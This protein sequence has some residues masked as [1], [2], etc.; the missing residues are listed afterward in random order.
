MSEHHEQVALFS[1]AEYNF[2][3]YPELRKMFAIPNGGKR[4]KKTAADLKKEGVKA[5]VPDIFLPVA[6]KGFHGLFIE[7]KKPKDHRSAAGRATKEQ[8]TVMAGLDDE[9][10]MTVLCVGFEAAKKTIEAYLS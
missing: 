2:N 3:K 9:G 6:R 10:Y 8:I 1:W 5:G 7:M 4:H